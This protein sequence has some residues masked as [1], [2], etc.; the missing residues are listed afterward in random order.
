MTA[1]RIWIGWIASASALSSRSRRWGWDAGYF[2]PAVCQ[3]LEERGIAGVMG[4]RTPNHKPGMFYKRSVQVRRVSQRI[5]VPAGAGPCRTDTTNRLGYREYK[6]NAQICGR[7]PVRSQCTNSAIAAKVVTR[8]V[9]E[10]AKER[11]DARRLTEWGQR[12]YA[13]RKQTV[14]RSFA[15]AKQLHGHRYA[16]MRGLRKVAE[17][18]LLAAAAQ[19]IKKIA[20]LLARKR[21]K[22]P[23]GPD[24]R[25]VR[26]L[27][28]LVSGLRCSFDYPL[29]ANPQS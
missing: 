19:N 26:M 18:C 6:S 2:T 11:V 24:W 5:R 21:K 17:Q 16:R 10:R 29:A 8:H 14:E 25:F 3:G 1:S 23:A 22:G 27:L 4:Y 9:W 20:M 28:R 12:I 15:D 7:C 13:R